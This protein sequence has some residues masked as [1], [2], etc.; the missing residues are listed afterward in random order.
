[1][2]LSISR[3]QALT[4]ATAA[5]L[6]ARTASLIANDK[7]PPSKT[8]IA[9]NT[10]PWRTFAR[11]AGQS[12]QRHTDQLLQNIASTGIVGYEPII[13]S[14]T[15]LDGLGDRLTKH[16]LYM[17]SIYVNSVLHDTAKVDQ[18]V[19]AAMA[20]AKRVRD[21][22]TSIVVTNPSPI[23]WGGDEDKD[24]SQLRFQAKSLDELGSELRKLGLT[25]AYHNHDAELR[26]GAREFHHMLTAT[27]QE[28]VKF[29][30]DSHWVFRGCGDSEVA[31]LDALDHYR[32]R[33]VELHLRQSTNGVWTE[34]FAMQGDV[35][36]QAIFRRLHES[37]IHPHLVLEQAIEQKSPNKLSATQAHKQGQRNLTKAIS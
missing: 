6:T 33:I 1:M 26:N 32:D 21:L 16:G 13:D 29:C 4:T 12:Y 28:N 17:R 5:L 20:I 37:N 7:T 10:Y 15:E 14:P 9:T 11:R 35:D 36:Y 31:V 19:A 24:D 3:R 23:R 30:L 18:S 8:H 22:G 34:A 27:K 25:L 2:P